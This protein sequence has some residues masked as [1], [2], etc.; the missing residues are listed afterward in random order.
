[1]KKILIFG[2]SG[3]IGSALAKKLAETNE[4]TI[5]DNNERGH[6]NIEIPS[7][8]KWIKSDIRDFD[9]VKS[10][11]KGQDIVYNLA[12]I[13]GTK[14][15]YEIPG[16]ILEIAGIGQIN[17]GSAINELGVEQFIYASSSEVFQHPNQI[18][19]PESVELIVPDVENPRYSYGGGK[20]FGE[21]LTLHHVTNVNQKKIFRP[22]NIFGPNMG[23]EHVIPQIYTKILAA[24]NDRIIDIQGDGSETRSF[25]Y[26]SD[27]VDAIKIIQDEGT[28]GVYHVGSG[29]EHKILDVINL[30]AELL[31]VDITIRAGELTPGSTKRRCPDISKLQAIG[32]SPKLSLKQGLMQFIKLDGVKNV[33]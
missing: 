14:Y 21:L 16:K 29:V 28:S 15:F 17:V 26:I 23:N 24:Q 11:V 22:H 25:C 30:V 8:I 9:K 1:M 2:G 13:N 4:V 7:H 6:S 10:S 32:F 19:T 18:P 3:F 20:I 5:F 31:Q 33:P 27:A 12:Y